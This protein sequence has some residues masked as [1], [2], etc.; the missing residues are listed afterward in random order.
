MFL[1]DYTSANKNVFDK[2]K[3]TCLIRIPTATGLKTI[4][5]CTT[6]F[7]HEKLKRPHMT[8]SMRPQVALGGDPRQP[9]GVVCVPR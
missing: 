9:R 2:D 8:R 6:S 3:D 1:V 5:T 7:L 4:S